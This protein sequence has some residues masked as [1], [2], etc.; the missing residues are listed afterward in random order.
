MQIKPG[1]YIHYDG[2]EYEV[3]GTATHSE[4]SEELVLYRA[5]TGED[6]T[7]AHPAASWNDVFEYNG[8]RVKRF[9]H[10]DEIVDLTATVNNNST[11][12]E[13]VKLFLSLFRGRGD[14]YAR[15][16]ESK[17]GTKSG[18]APVCQ[19]EWQP[20]IC[21]KPDIKCSSC[22]NRSLTP[23]NEYAISRHLKGHEVA[24]VYPMLPD[25]TCL[26]LSIDFD[27]E[28]WRKDISAAHAVCERNQIP[29]AMERSRSGNGGHLW[30]FFSDPI[31]AATARKLGSAILTAA[32][33]ERHEL[34]F[35]SYDRL[36]PN[37]DTMPKGGFGNLIALPLQKV[38]RNKGNSVFLD[39]QLNPY[40]D[41]WAFL[42]G[43]KHMAVNDV[44]RLITVL[45]KDGELGSLYRIEEDA[46]APWQMKLPEPGLNDKDF[47]PDLKAVMANMLYIPK[48]GL[49]PKALNQLKRLAAFKNPEFYKAQAMRFPT[50]GKP[51]VI[52][53]SDETEKYLCLPRGCKDEIC[54]MVKKGNRR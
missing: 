1:K 15:R 40:P 13:K 6:P 12:D 54:Q 46:D 37:Q 39:K 11:N 19:N 31:S 10:E 30:L 44:E 24:G 8:Q 48:E 33:E 36:F 49:S 52:S 35:T 16:W 5:L 34:K 20:G 47:P 9:I 27:G 45:S 14:V 51:R 32:M 53:I 18:Y 3:T 43:I 41:Q 4:T 2:K 26:F 29:C 25:E 38:P 17:D 42:S 22:K 7:W 21:G 28:G 23:F 50:W